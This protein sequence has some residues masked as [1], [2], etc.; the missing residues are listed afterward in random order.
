MTPL[1]AV[2][3][4]YNERATIRA[5]VER[6]RRQVERVIV[7]DDGSRDGTA[8]SLEGLP[9]S[10]VRNERNCGKALSLVRGIEEAFRL[11]ADAVVTLDGD[12]QHP[13]ED[14]PRLLA[15]HRLEPRAIVIGTRLHEARNIP[16]A[17]YLANRCA[18]FWIAW[19]AGQRIEDSQS[20]FRLYPLLTWRELLARCDDVT[21]FVFESEI[22]IEAGR[23]GVPLLGIPIPAIYPT[24]ARRSHFRP[25]A[26]IA[27][28]GRMVSWKLLSRGLYLPGLLRSLRDSRPDREA[29]LRRA[30]PSG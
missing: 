20:G 22:L 26:D 8:R 7:V 1:A 15:A 10:V 13:P 18:N 17:R 27:R 4:A 16:R 24:R 9:V 29:A 11:G 28:I 19:A 6:T 21:G 3:P 14:I 25:V 5:I 30:D 12:G 2:I 23:C